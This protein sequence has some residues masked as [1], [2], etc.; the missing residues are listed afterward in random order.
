MSATEWTFGDDRLRCE[1]RREGEHLS[2]SMR[3]LRSGR[4]WGPAPLLALEIHDRALQRTVRFGDYRID[5]VEA[6]DGGVHVIVGEGLR[7]ISIGLWLRVRNGELDVLLPPLEIYERWPDHFRLFAIDLL[8]G[9]LSVGADG[10]LILP[11]GEGALC[12]PAG[13]PAVQDRFLVYLEQARW[14]IC[15]LLPLAGA[16]DPRGGLA[17]LALEGDC[18]A[19]CR[20]ATDGQGRG[21]VGFAFSLRRYCPDPVDFDNRRFLFAP[22]PPEADPARFAAKR[23]RRHVMETLGKPTLKQRAAESPHVAYALQTFTT[24]TWHGMENEGWEMVNRDKSNPVT[25]QS[26]MTFAETAALLRRLREAGVDKLHVIV[27]GYQPRGHDGLYPTRF[28]IDERPGGESGF[29]SLIGS[30]KG[31]GYEISVHDDFMMN[32][33]HSPDY[34][35]DTVIRDLFGE[36]LVSG[37][38]GGG[39]EYQTWG[40]ALPDS[41]L[42]GHLERMRNLGLNGMYYCDYMLRPLEVNYHPRWRGPRSHSARGQVRILNEARRVFGAVSTELGTYPAALAVDSVCSAQG[43]PLPAD[44]PL[45]KLVDQFVP[46]WSYVFHGLVLQG[47]GNL[48]WR[49]VMDLILKGLHLHEAFSARFVKIPVLDDKRVA[50]YAAFYKLG[51]TRFGYLQAEELTEW[52]TPEPGVQTSVFGD[53]TRV[54]AD[55]NTLR[56]EVDGQEI[57]APAGLL[58]EQ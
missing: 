17:L 15:S 49:G 7:K 9:F 19:E 27:N 41:K 37:W 42:G 20:V 26:A 21:S 14:E 47:G 35:P 10:T 16:H 23:L 25:Y 43:R 55:F 8:P 32:V 11:I 12:R 56:L 4:N 38:W 52:A 51:V 5:A 13:K 58:P 18:D 22:I 53:G 31:L 34:D 24:K 57:K 2:F 36:P 45:A 3:D 29:R 40:L 44:W 1:L 39:L 50:A 28:P 48:T 33:P 46:L 54:R 6:V 30:A